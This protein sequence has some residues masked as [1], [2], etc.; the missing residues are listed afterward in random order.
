VPTLDWPVSGRFALMIITIDGPAGA[1]KSSA[2]K[3]L[4]KRMGFRFLDTGAMYRTVALAAM[5]RNI[6]W[7]DAQALTD[8]VREI[9]MQVSEMQVLLG[10]EDVTQEIR[11]L[12]VTSV[13]HHVADHRQIRAHLVNL[14]QRITANGD[15]V[16]EG[17]DQGTIA[18]PDAECKIFLTASAEE[19]ARRRMRDLHARGDKLEF[20]DVLARQNDRDARDVAR[21]VGRLIPAGDAIVVSTDGKDL[22][23]VVD[24]L[25][26]HARLRCHLTN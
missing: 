4:A 2:A 3:A 21:E 6:P 22:D 24:E 7:E 26:E 12:A 5:R 13:I 20:D 9:D 1:G 10:G 16:T 15:F 11:K 23:Q 17:R 8:L 14:Q 19:R 25:E 18:F